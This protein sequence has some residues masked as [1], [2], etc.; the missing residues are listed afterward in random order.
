LFLFLKI[1]SKT[2]EKLGAYCI[3]SKSFQIGKI[4]FKNKFLS[5]VIFLLVFSKFEK[6]LYSIFFLFKIFVNS[7]NKKVF[8]SFF[9]KNIFHISNFSIIEISQE[10]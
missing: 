8:F 5:R 1:N 7:L 10:M 2:N 3:F 6:K 9:V 4:G